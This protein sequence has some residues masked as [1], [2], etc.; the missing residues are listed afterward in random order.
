[1]KKKNWLTALLAGAMVLSLAACGGGDNGGS[2]PATDNGTP[3]ADT[4]TPAADAGNSTA[5]E[6]FEISMVLK[7]NSAEFWQIGRAS[8]RERV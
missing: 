7:T 8:C 5:D 2:T 6:P 4:G 1:M 3:A